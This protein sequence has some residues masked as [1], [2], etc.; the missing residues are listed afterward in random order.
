MRKF[1]DFS[2]TLLNLF[3][4]KVFENSK[5]S[6]IFFQGI[7]LEGVFRLSGDLGN[8]RELKRM[9]DSG[10]TINFIKSECTIADVCSL[11]KLYLKELPDP[12]IPDNLLDAVLKSDR[13]EEIKNVLGK[14]SKSNLYLLEALMKLMNVISQNS[15]VN[16]MTGND[17]LQLTHVSRKLCHCHG[18]FLYSPIKNG[19]VSRDSIKRVEQSL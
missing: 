4:L 15:A 8:V 18:T 16:M 9:I 5:K 17:I 13:P 7:S 2:K 19:R 14:L 1:L 3:F 11:I 6:L 12:V 10:Q